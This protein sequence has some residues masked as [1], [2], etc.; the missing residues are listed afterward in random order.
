LAL[1]QSV[2]SILLWSDVAFKSQSPLALVGETTVL[3]PEIGQ[4]IA[5]AYDPVLP[6]AAQDPTHAMRLAARIGAMQ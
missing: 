1:S 2:Q 4:V 5:A 3:R 6:V